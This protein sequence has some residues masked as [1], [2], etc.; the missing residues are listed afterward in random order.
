MASEGSLQEIAAG[1]FCSLVFCVC[2]FVSP[3]CFCVRW[4]GRRFFF[5]CGRLCCRLPF[6][7][8]RRGAAQ[9]RPRHSSEE[10]TPTARGRQIRN[11]VFLIFIFVLG[12][13]HFESKQ[14]ALRGPL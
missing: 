11:F 7:L 12:A 5:L 2:V 8:R 4:P 9:V 10:G 3:L 1:S 13:L 6:G 14:F